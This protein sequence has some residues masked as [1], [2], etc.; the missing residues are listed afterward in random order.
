MI[1]N[2]SVPPDT[3]LPHVVYQNVVDAIEWLTRTFGFRECYRYGEPVSGAQMQ[4][5]KAWIMLKG[6]ETAARARR[7]WV[8]GRKASPCFSK[9][10]KRTSKGRKRRAPRS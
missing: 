6:R 8:T 9:I 3:L 5:G 4:I 10:S 1:M 2:R 7:N